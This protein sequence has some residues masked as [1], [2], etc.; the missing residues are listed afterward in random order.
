MSEAAI[1]GRAGS[2]SQLQIQV[3]SLEA[4][5]ARNSLGIIQV[6]HLLAPNN[7]E[8]PADFSINVDVRISFTYLNHEGEESQRDVR[9]SRVWYGCTMYY[10]KRQFLLT[11]HDYN[12]G[13]SRTFA[14]ANISGS[15]SLLS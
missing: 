10:P 8:V 14:V 1:K 4:E 11:A 15:I 5:C 7:I 9:T 13:A 6:I 2:I 12:R 3:L